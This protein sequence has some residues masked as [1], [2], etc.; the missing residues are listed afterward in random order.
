MSILLDC[1]EHILTW[2]EAFTVVGCAVCVL[3]FFCF[4]IWW[5]TR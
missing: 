3:T 4:G 5:T 1:A 2:P